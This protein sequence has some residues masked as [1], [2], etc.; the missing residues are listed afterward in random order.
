AMDEDK[1]QV[2][3]V[4]RKGYA[5][6]A[7][8]SEFSLKG[9]ATQGVRCLRPSKSA[10]PVADVVVGLRGALDVYLEDGRRQRVDLSDI[11]EGSREVL[12]KRLFGDKQPVT[13][14]VL[15]GD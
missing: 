5:H 3:V 10:G 8:L 6:R 1:W 7:P 4:S 14:L 2:V 11:P 15:L 9:R 13:R 12:G